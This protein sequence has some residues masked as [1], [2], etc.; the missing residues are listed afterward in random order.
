M[1]LVN[2][3]V[4]DDLATYRSKPWFYGQYVAVWRHLDGA[5][6]LRESKHVSA[7]FIQYPSQQEAFC[8]LDSL[9]ASQKALGLLH[10]PEA[11]GKSELIEQIARKVSERAAVAVIDGS[12]LKP[13]AFLTKLLT[14]FGYDLEL[15]S[16]DELLNMLS[17]FTVQQARSREAPVLILEHFNHM[18]PSALNVL[19]QLAMLTVSNRF[20]LRIILVGDK[21]FGRVIDSPRM[22]PIA[23]RLEGDFEMKPLTARESVVYL[24]E[25]L[26]ARGI[27]NPDSIFPTDICD[28]LY[29][30]SGGWPGN[31]DSIAESTLEKLDESPAQF[32]GLDQS[33]ASQ[34][35]AASEMVP[36]LD[37]A[38]DLPVLLETEPP[39]LIVSHNGKVVQELHL[40]GPRTLLG[41]S[42]LSDVLI[43]NQYVSKHHALIVWAEN[44]VLLIDLKS[45]NGTYVNSERVKSQILN[46]NDIVSLGEYRIKMLFPAAAYHV[47]ATGLDVA[48]TLKMQNLVDA[49]REKAREA[50]RSIEARQPSQSR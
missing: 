17:V 4:R 43:D 46:D 2:G 11:A 47:T 30:T 34:L 39:Q 7:K 32:E 27:K 33:E 3:I 29:E 22:L 15:T 8:F 20:A 16:V 35:F 10:G 31:L 26:Q 36:E 45:R 23:I 44:A 6:N 48:D 49:R 40:S 12:R 41:R 42:E 19:C 13:T 9:L 24:Y 25:R 18:Y 38:E 50:L 14:E 1:I 37:E 28:E 21:Y 5:Q